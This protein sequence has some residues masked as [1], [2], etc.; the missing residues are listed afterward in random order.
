M[1]K[2]LLC[3]EKLSRSSWEEVDIQIVVSVGQALG[4]V[5]EPHHKD[6]LECIPLRLQL[7]PVLDCP[8]GPKV[9]YPVIGVGASSRAQRTLSAERYGRGGSPQGHQ[10][11]RPNTPGTQLARGHLFSV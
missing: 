1:I 9:P 8:A 10:G 5:L 6:N 7:S 4:H 11:Q 3:W 2:L